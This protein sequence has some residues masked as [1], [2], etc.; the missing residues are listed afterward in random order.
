MKTLLSRVSDRPIGTRINIGFGVVL[1]L[2]CGIATFDGLG[3][4]TIDAA[5]F[6][7]DT[8]A[9]SSDSLAEF[10]S[11]LVGEDLQVTRYRRSPGGAELTGVQR[12]QKEVR[13]RL[14]KVETLIGDEA[15]D[16]KTG[17]A[18][19]DASFELIVADTK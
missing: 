16:L 5:V 9:A 11:S 7:I 17:L 14:A 8:T 6:Q 4:R 2:L 19:L 12:A 18:N 15:N 3:L 10:A 1:L 13:D